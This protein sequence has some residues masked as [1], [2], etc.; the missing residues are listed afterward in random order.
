MIDYV[1]IYIYF[2]GNIPLL[3]I[4]LDNLDILKLWT[5]YNILGS[6]SRGRGNRGVNRNNNRGTREKFTEDFNFEESNAKFNK[7][8][9]EKELLKVLNKVKISD[10][11]YLFYSIS[12][13]EIWNIKRKI[14][15]LC[16]NFD[17]IKWVIKLSFIMIGKNDSTEKTSFYHIFDGKFFYIFI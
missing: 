4:Y 17:N 2:F 12:I 9:I 13:V 15:L 8:E 3:W 16:G 6:G 11:R 10:V 5:A 7:E 1:Y 14:V